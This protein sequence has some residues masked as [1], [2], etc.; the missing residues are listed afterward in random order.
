MASPTSVRDGAISPSPRIEGVWNRGSVMTGLSPGYGDLTIIV[1]SSFRG[2][3]RTT[4]GRR[5]MRGRAGGLRVSSLRGGTDCTTVSIGGFTASVRRGRDRRRSRR[6]ISL[7]IIILSIS[8]C[9]NSTSSTISTKIT[10]EQTQ[11][12][13]RS[14]NSHLVDCLGRTCQTGVRLLLGPIH[15]SPI[16]TILIC[17]LVVLLIRWIPVV[18]STRVVPN[19]VSIILYQ[20]S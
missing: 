2:L 16:G 8:C 4:R 17:V 7:S 1:T 15:Y 13:T 18:R 9:G 12:S 10:Y 6:S 11:P 5:P 20:V 3:G 19:R 14:R